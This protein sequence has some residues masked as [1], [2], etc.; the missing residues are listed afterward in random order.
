MIIDEPERND[1][2]ILRMNIAKKKKEKRKKKKRREKI[3][4]RAAAQQQV[5]GTP[6]KR[7]VGMGGW[8]K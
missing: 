8:G 4:P 6:E 7:G 3:A 5:M 2:D 1:R